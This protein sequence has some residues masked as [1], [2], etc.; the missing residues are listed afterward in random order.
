MTDERGD[1]VP[2]GEGGAAGGNADLRERP[3]FG[4]DG[5][6]LGR[7]AEVLGDRASSQARYLGIALDPSIARQPGGKRVFVPFEAARLDET[8]RVYLDGVTGLAAPDLPAHPT[9][10]PLPAA[11]GLAALSTA[12]A[13]SYTTRLD[14]R[15]EDEAAEEARITLSEEELEIGKEVVSAG[16]VR[17]RKHVETERVRETVPVM[18]EDVTVE[19]RPLPPGAGLEPRFEGDV[20]YVPIVEE[21]LVIQKRL[22]AREELVIRKRRVTEEQVVEETLRRERAEVIEP[23][24]GD[25]GGES[26]HGEWA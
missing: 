1:L 13:A 8:R 14:R 10:G 23:D 21:E 12:P 24:G 9:D 22:V 2:L 26:V 19:R 5:T 6:L 3:V 11:S 16:E 15:L 4:G 25:G 20:V 17:V 18:R 7:V